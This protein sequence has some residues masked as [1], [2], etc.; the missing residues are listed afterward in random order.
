M[1]TEAERHE[2]ELEELYAERDKQPNRSSFKSIFLTIALIGLLPG[3]CGVVIAGPGA[4]L[5]YIG[6]VLVLSLIGKVFSLRQD[7]QDVEKE[8]TEKTATLANLRSIN[9]DSEV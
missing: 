2:K 7:R 8:I 9:R 3:A 4:I 5:V 6:I 1:E